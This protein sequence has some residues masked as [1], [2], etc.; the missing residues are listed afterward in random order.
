MVDN[1]SSAPATASAIVNNLHNNP[2][3][4]NNAEP[5]SP[6]TDNSSKN[7][8]NSLDDARDASP[9]QNLSVRQPND[10]KRINMSG[11]GG[12]ENFP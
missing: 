12:S 4:I 2:A 10:P 1:P 3:L 11:L 7:S 9:Q 8:N 5:V 6:N